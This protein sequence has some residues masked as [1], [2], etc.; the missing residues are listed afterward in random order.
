[1]LNNDELIIHEPKTK[2]IEVFKECGNYRDSGR[3]GDA[4]DKVAPRSWITKLKYFKF[5][6]LNTDKLTNLA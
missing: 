4:P 3:Q 5:N 1:M 6:I 2:I